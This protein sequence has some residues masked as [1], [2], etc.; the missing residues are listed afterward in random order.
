MSKHF[1]LNYYAI[2]CSFDV[3]LQE[4][5]NKN[6]K[7]GFRLIINDSRRDQYNIEMLKLFDTGHVLNVVKKYEKKLRVER[8]L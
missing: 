7:Y 4:E 8:H 6:I 5:T 3:Y 1:V 2:E